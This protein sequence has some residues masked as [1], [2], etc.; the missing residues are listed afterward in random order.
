M[1]PITA[2]DQPFFAET[3]RLF[4]YVSTHN[5]DALA[6]LCDDDFGIVDLGPSGENIMIRTRAEWEN[7]F[8]TLFAKLTEMQA[9]TDTDITDYKA[10]QMADMGYSVVEFCQNLR[11]GGQVGRFQCVTTIIWKKTSQGWQESRWHVSL[12]SQKWEAE[13]A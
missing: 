6:A 3:R 12:L 1:T 11:V 13:V 4:D 10:L 9:A 2:S 8:R 7:W 5:F